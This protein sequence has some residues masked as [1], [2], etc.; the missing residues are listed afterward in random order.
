MTAHDP[1]PPKRDK[2]LAPETPF[3]KPRDGRLR[4]VADVGTAGTLHSLADPGPMPPEVPY[5]QMVAYQCSDCGEDCI[6]H[7]ETD[8]A[9]E[10]VC[11]V[12]MRLPSL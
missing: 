9:Q 1:T 5:V 7:R 12:C 6:N 2:S 11:R 4:S 3:E 8:P 10:G